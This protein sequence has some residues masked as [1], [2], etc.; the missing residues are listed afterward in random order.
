VVGVEVFRR[1]YAAIGLRG[2]VA[3]SRL[4]G[5]SHGLELGYRI[6]APLR[7]R[8]RPQCSATGNCRTSKTGRTGRNEQKTRSHLQNPPLTTGVRP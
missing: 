8:L 5:I 4:P 1:L 6:F 7:L 3:I 2:L